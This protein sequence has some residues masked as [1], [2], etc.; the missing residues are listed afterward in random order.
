MLYE[1]AGQ[2]TSAIKTKTESAQLY[3]ACRDY[4]LDTAQYVH[5]Y[6]LI[7]P[8]ASTHR[9]A[10]S[11]HRSRTVNFDKSILT[12]R[13]TSHHQRHEGNKITMCELEHACRDINH[14]KPRSERRAPRCAAP[15]PASDRRPF[16]IV[17]C[18]ACPEP[19]SPLSS[20]TSLI[21]RHKDC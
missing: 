11:A 21:F 17:A 4:R 7:V 19:R 5:R 16:E 2:R 13:V 20:H 1:A 9:S 10:L 15:T 18:S 12:T 6:S 14:G 8:I 3:G